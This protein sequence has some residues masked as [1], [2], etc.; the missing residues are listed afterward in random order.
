MPRKFAMNLSVVFFAYSRPEL[1]ANSVNSFNLATNS[2]SWEKVLVWQSGFEEMRSKVQDLRSS[3]DL[4]V[5]TKGNQNTVLAN[6][7]FNRVLGMRLAFDE[8]KADFV[9][10]IEEDAVVSTDS[11]VFIEQICKKFQDA[12]NFMGINLG[13]VEPRSEHDLKG[14]SRLRYGLQ[15]Q[16]GGVTK[17]AWKRCHGLLKAYDI[18]NVG[19]DSR[20]EF[21]LKTGFMVTPNVSRM[22]DYGWINGTH[23][24]ADSNNIHFQ[25]LRQSQFEGILDSE[26]VY[27][28]IPIHHTWRKDVTLY[29]C[30]N[31]LPAK[32][33]SVDF[34]RN[35]AIYLKGLGKNGFLQNRT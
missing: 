35:F 13:S 31:A 18:E 15:G 22:N 9:L 6:I 4:I 29:S 28:E 17:N 12:R 32:L 10:G 3:F 5:E 33:R 30:F 16:A 7:N 8:L 23:S 21:Y 26:L 20:L 14:Y 27:E 11:L 19:W 1:L 34:V 2:S 25:L 24:S